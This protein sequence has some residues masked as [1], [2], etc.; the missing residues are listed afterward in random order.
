MLVPAPYKASERKAKKKAKGAKGVP[1]R[2]GTSDVTS[3][4]EETRS[5]VPEDD[6]EEEEEIPPRDEGREKRAASTNLEMGTTKKRKG[7]LADNSVRDVDSS[8]ERRSRAKPQAA[9]CVISVQLATTSSDPRQEASLLSAASHVAEVSKLK[10]RLEKAEE[11]LGQVKRQLQENQADKAEADLEER[12]AET[13]VWFREAHEEPRAAQGELVERKQELILK[14]TDVKKA[15]EVAKEQAT[16]DKAAWQQHQALLNSQEEE[17]AARE[18]ALAATFRGKDEEELELEREELKK[19][20]SALTAERDAANRTLADVQVAIS[21][22]AKLLSE[23]SDSINDLK[24]KLDG[25]EGKLSEAGAHEETLNK[26]LEDEK[27][28]RRNHAAEHEEFAKGI[29]L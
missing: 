9:S 22:Q 10:E 15:Q 12:V 24:L 28:L 6:K 18:E 3:E 14:Q 25:L 4:D 11:E 20:V 2:K 5:S 17:L 23:A 8:P 26:V 29:N 7:S 21:D 1:R 27:Q 19:R 13:Q 16:K